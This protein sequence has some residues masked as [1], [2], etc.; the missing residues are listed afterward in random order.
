MPGCSATACSASVRSAGRCSLIAL[1]DKPGRACA[2]LVCLACVKSPEHLHV[3]ARGQQFGCIIYTRM[4]GCECIGIHPSM[5]CDE[6]DAITGVA[7]IHEHMGMHGMVHSPMECMDGYNMHLS[8]IRS[9]V[10]PWKHTDQISTLR[11]PVDGRS[12]ELR[13]N[14]RF[15]AASTTSVGIQALQT[16]EM[17]AVSINGDSAHTT[18]T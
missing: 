4:H 17:L 15:A 13:A 10:P 6:R 12:S 5:E 8:L 1:E 3:H 14:S 7:C 11:L 18:I 9:N 2:Y 16:C